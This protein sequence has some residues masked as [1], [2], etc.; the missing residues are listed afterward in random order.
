MMARLKN[1]RF[2]LAL[3]LGVL[4]AACDA[5]PPSVGIARGEE[6]FDTCAPCHGDMGEGNADIDAPAIA[7]LPQWY[8]EAQLESFKAGFR[9]KH[10]DDLPALRMRPMAILI[11]IHI[12]SMV[13]PYRLTKCFPV[14]VTV[15][16]GFLMCYQSFLI[17][18][19]KV[20]QKE[21][22]NLEP[23]TQVLMQPLAK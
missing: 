16:H 8:L 19:W 23:A 7:G 6:L 2:T 12:I 5:T 4:V 10:V 15:L 3:L 9:G 14:M 18:L 11:L 20:A 17:T 1:M 21:T 22:G 13:T